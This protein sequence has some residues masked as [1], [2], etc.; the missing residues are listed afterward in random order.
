MRGQN[1]AWPQSLVAKC[2]TQMGKKEIS[3]D[4]PDELDALDLQVLRRYQ[5]NTRMPAEKIAAEVGLSTAAVQRR[6]RRMREGRVIE[7]EVAK[8]APK[9]VGM[10][11]TCLVGVELDREGAAGIDRFKAKMLRYPQVQ[12]CYY[13]TGPSDFMLVVLARD[14]EAYEL[15]SRKALLDDPNVRSFTTYVVLDRVKT[16][17]GVPIEV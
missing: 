10:N 1:D 2:V 3:P 12:Q 5:R 13:V 4:A 15:F 16:E 8:V 9:A 6:L 7:G 17:G 14:M 11:I